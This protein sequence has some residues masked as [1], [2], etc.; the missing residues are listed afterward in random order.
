VTAVTE[1]VAGVLA[2]VY[3][4]EPE[5]EP[6]EWAERTLKV[7]R[8]EN[9]EW[10]D[11]YWSSEL[12]PYVREVLEW[13]KRPGKGEFWIKKSSQVGFT[14]A[15]LILICWMIVHRSGQ[16][17]YA[18]DSLDEA[19]KLS[20]TRLKKWI[21]SN[22]ILSEVEGD[23]DDE[24][25]N[26]T[27]FLSG[28]TV[29]LMGAHST[30]AWA[31]KSLVLAILDELDKHPLVEGA[32]TSDHARE[33]VKRPRD[34]K[35]IGFSTPGDSGLITVEHAKGTREVIDL[36][37]PHCEA[38]APLE[39]KNFVYDTKEFRDLA[40]DLDLEKVAEGAYFKCELCGG[41]F[42]EKHKAAALLRYQYRATNPKAPPGVRSVHIWDAYS[43]FVTF[44]QL[45]I[46]RINADGNPAKMERFMN[47]RRGLAYERA[48]GGVS[49][50]ELLDLKGAYKRGEPP[51]GIDPLFYA[52]A[53]DVQ[54]DCY[55]ATKAIFAA[56]GEIYVIDWDTLVNFEE[57]LE[58]ADVPLVVAGREMTVQCG[59]IDEG[60]G[61]DTKAVREFCL[62]NGDR[63]Y[64]VKGRGRTQIDTMITTSETW[65][66]GE[67]VM[68]YHVNDPM[69]K[70]DLLFRLRKNHYSSK[71]QASIVPLYL[72]AD[73]DEDDA[74]LK[75]LTQEIP[76]KKKNSFGH[77][78]WEWVKKGE[79]DFWDTLKYLLPQWSIVSPVLLAARK[80][81]DEAA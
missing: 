25:S 60:N 12:T 14:M 21:T 8:T 30:G 57:I 79:N 2:G 52:M 24:L 46:E 6:W 48:G 1:W 16:V 34:A 47:G 26:L 71:K 77:E 72:P 23:E 27:Y 3:Q 32:P 45:A 20:K 5:E 54:R 33:R 17:A 15:I 66:E 74:F 70:W 19:R 67:E 31:N 35:I 65:H 38:M 76:V 42:E 51:V 62:A 61:D 68:T 44:G 13:A 78:K 7:P 75:E 63:F 10:A 28:I 40:G 56:S 36:P 73:V 80:D 81:E 69:F 43:R 55:K 39:W 9:E 22:R 41:R 64:P 50:S 49:T 4:P 59:L 11:R 58:F 53:V 29:Y 37:C 18:I